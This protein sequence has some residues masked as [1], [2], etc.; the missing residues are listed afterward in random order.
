[1]CLV[2]GKASRFNIIFFIML[3]N[4]HQI[5]AL[6]GEYQGVNL[7]LGVLNVIMLHE[8]RIM[9]LE[10]QSQIYIAQ[11]TAVAALDVQGEQTAEL[12]SSLKVSIF[13]V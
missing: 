4:F 12:I 2:N 8:D 9:E 3:I 5:S 13:L 11:N 10:D 1:V 7:P 6:T